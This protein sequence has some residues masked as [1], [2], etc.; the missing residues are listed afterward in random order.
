MSEVTPILEEEHIAPYDE[1][2]EPF[3][4]AVARTVEHLLGLVHVL[5][6]LS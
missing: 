3:H 1:R 4:P 2:S 5:L 6:R